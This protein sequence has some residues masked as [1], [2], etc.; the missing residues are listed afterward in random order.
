MDPQINIV[1][2]GF[3]T[4]NMVS[5]CVQEKNPNF[6]IIIII[7]KNCKIVTHAKI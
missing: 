5:I 2:H 6:A 4:F 7:Y 3:I 1:K